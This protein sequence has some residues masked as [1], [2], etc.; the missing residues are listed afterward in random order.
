MCGIIGVWDHKNRISKNGF[1]KCL[2]TL[3]HRGPD[4]YGVFEEEGLFMGMRRLSIIDIEGGS[5][6]VYSQDER[7]VLVFNGE[8]YNYLEIK[9]KLRSEG[10]S[11]RSSSD[12]EVLLQSL[13]KGVEGIADLRGMFAFA[14]FDRVQR[15]LLLCRDRLGV[16]PLYYMN[17]PGDCFMFASE[18]KGI[19]A[20]CK[21]LNILLEIE[22]KSIYNY[23][24]FLNVPQPET[25]YKNVKSLFR[26]EYLELNKEGDDNIQKYW[27]LD[28]RSK[29]E[30]SFEETIHRTREIIAES[31]KI[32]LR[33]DVP[34]G[35]FLSGG[36]DSSIVAYEASQI[37]QNLTTFTVAIEGDKEFDESGIAGRTAAALGLKNVVLPLKINVLDTLQKIVGQY[38]QPFADPSA[39]PSLG[40]SEL[41][42]NHVKVVLNGD[43]GDEQFAGYRRYVLTQHLNKLKVIPRF[44]GKLGYQLLEGADR[45]SYKGFLQRVLRISSLNDL[46]DRY[47]ALTTDTFTKKE[48]QEL[49]VHNKAPDSGLFE[50]LNKNSL[51]GIVYQTHMD[52]NI[53]LPSGLLVKMDIASSA[54]SLEAR[55]PLMDHKLFEFS[56]GIP[57]K[58]KVNKGITKYV[59]RKAYETELSEEVVMGKKKGF[60]IPLKSW[61]G[62]E[63]YD[64]KN[65]LLSNSSSQIYNYLDHNIIKGILD[66]KSFTDRN[67]SYII[68]SLIVLEAWLNNFNESQ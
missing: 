54:F 48:K 57:D 49:W 29:N 47:V 43:G 58:F 5:Q 34:V 6:P 15:K 44:A 40:I 32:R 16:K 35:I 41:A 61:L 52:R 36:L 10:K 39:I 17:I 62:N 25:I 37:G 45:R 20:L 53:N 55:S 21:E 24:S 60:E 18:L 33:S 2:D 68:Y 31:V 59:L 9:E 23:L 4:D 13:E 12:S 65:D 11:F 28:Y 38:D 27:E 46:E 3:S 30:L 51:K 19:K 22:P 14:H 26:A 42:G 8:I 67:T 50:S 64:F 63:L 7:R 56:S 1:K 66:E